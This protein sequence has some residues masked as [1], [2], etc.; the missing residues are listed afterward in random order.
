MTFFI[1]GVSGTLGQ[2]VCKMLLARGHKVVGY[3]RDEQ[4]QRL[5]PKCEN[6]TLYLGDIRDPHRLLEATRGADIILHFASL[7]CVD[8][9]QENPEEAVATNVIGTQNVL[10]AQRLHGIKKVLFTSTDKAVYPIN[11]YGNSKALAE[12]LVL[13]NPNNVVCRYGNV[14]GSRGSVLPMFVASLQHEAL[15]R[16]TDKRMT[17]FW[18]TV[19]RAAGFVI[20]CALSNKTTGLQIPEI[21]SCSVLSLVDAVAEHLGVESYVID[22]VGIRPGEKLHECL[23]A[24]TETR[25][26]EPVYSDY[27]SMSSEELRNLLGE[28]MRGI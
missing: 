13:R 4:K 14:L 17:R 16:V 19:E 9:L 10:R 20:S 25:D 23:M 5:M 3:S 18:T 11:A 28:A 1:S 6:L 21:E 12:W 26:G 22:E 7:K 24:H 27:S 2:T 15:A 8:T